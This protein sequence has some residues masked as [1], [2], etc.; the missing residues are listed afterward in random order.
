M[1][2]SKASCCFQSASNY[3]CLQQKL[4]FFR[5]SETINGLEKL[6]SVPLHSVPTTTH[7]KIVPPASFSMRPFEFLNH[8]HCT[9]SECCHKPRKQGLKKKKKSLDSLKQV[10][11]P[12]AVLKSSN[13]LIKAGKFLCEYLC[14]NTVL[15]LLVHFYC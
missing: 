7:T 8:V 15:L 4:S 2:N 12:H 13:C 5:I 3:S 10:I 9:K 11:F 6:I 14:M 1:I